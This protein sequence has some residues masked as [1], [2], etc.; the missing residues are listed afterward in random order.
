MI[1]CAVCQ[2]ENTN[3][4]LFSRHFIGAENDEIREKIAKF[5]HLLNNIAIAIFFESLYTVQWFFDFTL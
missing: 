2:V 5:I 3:N 4:S 1:S